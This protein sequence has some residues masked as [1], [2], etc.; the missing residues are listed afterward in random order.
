MN[1][2]IIIAK[3][4]RQQAEIREMIAILKEDRRNRK[5]IEALKKRCRETKKLIETLEEKS[6]IPRGVEEVDITPELKKIE[7]K[8]GK[9]KAGVER[10]KK[11]EKEKARIE[12]KI[13]E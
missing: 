6:F 10:L 7:K 8:V 2:E 5:I 3:I 11:L 13:S 12:K 4:K 9:V 1:K